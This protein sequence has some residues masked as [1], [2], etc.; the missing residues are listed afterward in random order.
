MH[1]SIVPAT[2]PVSSR[3]SPVQVWQQ[4]LKYLLE[5]HYGLTLDD[6]PFH[7]NTAIEEHIDAG[8]TLVDAVNFLVE[9]YELVRIDRK[10]FSWQD[11]TPFL[12]ATDILRARRATGI[13]ST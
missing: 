4:L 1:I 6:T 11:Q 10:G 2:V 9:R 3:L 13:M 8:I 7:D 5:H 12:S